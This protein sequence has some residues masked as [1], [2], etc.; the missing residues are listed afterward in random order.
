M[1]CNCE[2]RDPAGVLKLNVPQTEKHSILLSTLLTE[3]RGQ[4]SL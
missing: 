3:L 2:N 1:F 4:E